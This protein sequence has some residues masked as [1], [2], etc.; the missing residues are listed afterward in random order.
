MG[1]IRNTEQTN[2]LVDFEVQ[3]AQ[4]L[5]DEYVINNVKRMWKELGVSEAF[6]D[7]NFETE[8]NQF[9]DSGR[10][11]QELQSFVCVSKTGEVVGSACC[12]VW[13]G[14]LPLCVANFKWGTVWGLYVE[15]QFRN[16]GLGCCILEECIAHLKTLGCNRCIVYTLGGSSELFQKL[17][18]STANGLSLQIEESRKCFLRTI[19]VEGTEVRIEKAGTEMDLVSSVNFK[20]M[21][22]EVGVDQLCPD[23]EERTLQFMEHARQELQM[24]NF[25]AFSENREPLGSACCQIWKGPLPQSH[26]KWGSVWGIYVKPQ[27]RR[28]GIGKALMEACISHWQELGCTEALLIYASEDGKRIYEKLGFKKGDALF[29]EDL[30]RFEHS[31]TQKAAEDLRSQLPETWKNKSPRYLRQLLMTVPHQL[32]SLPLDSQVKQSVASTQKQHNIYVDEEDNWFT[33]NLHKMGGG[34]DMEVLCNSELLATKFDKLSKYWEDFVTGC[35]YIKVF[36]WI[37]EM[38]EVAF[39]EANT[40][41]DLACGIGL[42]AHTLRLLNFK[43]HI[44][45]IDISSG[46]LEKAAERECYNQIIKADLNKG[47]PFATNSADVVVCT[48]STELLDTVHLLTECNRVLKKQ[49]EVLLSFQYNDLKSPNPTA[50]QNVSG[51]TFQE[52]NSQ[53]LSSG[54]EVVSYQ[55]CECAFVTPVSS[56]DLLP[57]P[58][59]FLRSRKL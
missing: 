31:L 12:Q 59:I 40:V 1:E 53:M 44:T 8:I 4:S 46:M 49:G 14:P 27:F 11:E 30:S 19:N 20:E 18:F 32:N 55:V 9:L 42:M 36:E 34:F 45:G 43:G 48:G 3:K 23:F 28:K 39:E 58:Y 50:H 54:F 51:V 56:G 37:V 5:L 57:V 16:L 35:G 6:L 47:I 2:F 25:V 26:C 15:P 10:Q 21:W 52:V 22:L 41:V 24:A 38:K 13:K 29:L 17:G 7:G 33:R